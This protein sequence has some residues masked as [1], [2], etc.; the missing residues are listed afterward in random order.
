MKNDDNR[1]L[2]NLFV[3][4]FQACKLNVTRTLLQRLS[5]SLAWRLDREVSLDSREITS[6]PEIKKMY[7]L[8]WT[9]SIIAESKP[10]AH[11]KSRLHTMKVYNTRPSQF[12]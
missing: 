10:H 6:L 4:S 3:L 2:D 9:S 12:C 8:A 11:H 7:Y 1:L 5:L